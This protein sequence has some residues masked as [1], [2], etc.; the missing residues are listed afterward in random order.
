MPW[1]PPHSRPKPAGSSLPPPPA[2]PHSF[3]IPGYLP[4]NLVSIISVFSK[5][6]NSF[7][8][9]AKFLPPCFQQGVDVR[10]DLAA[11]PRPLQTPNYTRG[12]WARHPSSW[13]LLG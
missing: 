2:T 13:G 11:G 6:R 12:L 4:S 10:M 3:G 9:K 7:G 5:R 1:T 8:L